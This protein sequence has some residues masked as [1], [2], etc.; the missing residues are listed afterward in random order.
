MTASVLEGHYGP[1][2]SVDTEFTPV[3]QE[4]KRIL[5]ELAVNTP[6]FTQDPTLIDAVN[7]HGSDLPCISGPLKTQAFTAVLHAM[8]GI[9][10]HEI[11]HLRG[12]P[13]DNKTTIFTDQVG[14]HLATPA[15]VNVDGT[16]GPAVLH[17]PALPHADHGAY[18]TPIKLRSQ[19]IYQTR[20]PGVWFQLH[21]STDPAP[22]L[23]SIGI[24]PQLE[25]ASTDEAYHHIQEHTKKYSARDLEMIMLE[26]G[27]AG[28][29]VHSP[30]SWLKTTMGATLAK[31][32]L[33]NYKK[34]DET[35]SL[36][37][38]VFPLLESDDKRPLVGIKVLEITRII[39]GP[40]CGAVLSS[41]GAD[42]VRVQAG[43][44]VDFT[45]S[46]RDDDFGSIVPKASDICA[47]TLAGR[48]AST[49]IPH[50]R[51]TELRARHR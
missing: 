3:P 15:V 7:F 45:V 43:R 4:C 38:T 2:T 42:V 37:P 6:G 5:H 30:E 13:T 49:T 22:V 18:G 26:N 36:M 47:L 12:V 32:P 51:Q 23:R 8:A 44:Q 9:V 24:N 33:L 40:A 28:S 19:A 34:L 21:G 46:S 10:G 11:L 31:H 16:D 1:G 39:A 17:N 35:P 27:L 20:T 29:I 41:M 14:L 48:L 25:I 50:G